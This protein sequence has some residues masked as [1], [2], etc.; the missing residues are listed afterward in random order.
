MIKRF[1]PGFL[2]GVLLAG[3]LVAIVMSGVC[4]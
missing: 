1:L 3:I 2:T 4:R